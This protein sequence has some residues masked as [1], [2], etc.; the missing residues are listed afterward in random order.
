MTAWVAYDHEGETYV[1]LW[2]PGTPKSVYV[3]A[4]SDLPGGFLATMRDRL[5][6]GVGVPVQMTLADELRETV[7]PVR[8][9]RSGGVMIGLAGAETPNKA[10]EADRPSADR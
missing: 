7:T 3:I 9:I 4:E 6:Q 10:L 1:H 8:S 5:P 2:A